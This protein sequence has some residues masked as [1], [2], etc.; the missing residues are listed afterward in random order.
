[1]NIDLKSSR[2]RE[3]LFGIVFS[4][5]CGVIILPGTRDAQSPILYVVIF[6]GLFVVIPLVMAIGCLTGRL[7]VRGEQNHKR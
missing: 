6:G 3:G 2:V 4:V 7:P 5:L 1:M